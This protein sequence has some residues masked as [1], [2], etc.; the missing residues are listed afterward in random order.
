M[1]SIPHMAG[2]PGDKQSADYLFRLWKSE[3]KLDSVQMSDYDVL[4]DF[5]DDI[6]FNKLFLNNSD[7]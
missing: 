5:P 7:E 2:T 4:L 3:Y 1:T 6:K